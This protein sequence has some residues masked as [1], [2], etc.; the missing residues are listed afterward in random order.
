MLVMCL[1]CVKKYI[2]VMKI[3]EDIKMSLGIFIFFEYC[4][5]LYIMNV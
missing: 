3:V 4:G 1:Y 2:D 5:N